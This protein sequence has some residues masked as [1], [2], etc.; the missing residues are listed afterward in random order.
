MIAK[1]HQLKIHSTTNSSSLSSPEFIKKERSVLV[2]HHKQRRVSLLFLRISYMIS[3]K[4]ELQFRM[5]RLVKSSLSTDKAQ[6]LQFPL[7]YTHNSFRHAQLFNASTDNDKLFVIRLSVFVSGFGRHKLV[8][9]RTL[10]FESTNFFLNKLRDPLKSLPYNSSTF[11]TSMSKLICT[12]QFDICL[13]FHSTQSRVDTIMDSFKSNSFSAQDQRL[14]KSFS[15]STY[16]FYRMT[17]T[18]GA[19]VLIYDALYE[20]LFNTMGI[21]ILSY[22]NFLTIHSCKIINNFWLFQALTINSEELSCSCILTQN[23]QCLF[24]ISKPQFPKNAR[25]LVLILILYATFVSKGQIQASNRGRQIL[26]QQRNVF[27]SINSYLR[28][29][30]FTQHEQLSSIQSNRVKVKSSFKQVKAVVQIHI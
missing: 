30:K 8:S 29:S 9:I 10:S 22:N 16:P 24:A 1:F 15:L 21:N 25:S 3:S 14:K 12:P 13:N 28:W 4:V 27:Q 5:V 26:Q 19:A 7:T 6:Q 11:F 20:L 18:G 23:I 17:D 2:Q